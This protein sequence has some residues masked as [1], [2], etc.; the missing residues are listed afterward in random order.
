MYTGIGECSVWVWRY[1]IIHQPMSNLCCI[2]KKYTRKSLRWCV[3][4]VV[5]RCRLECMFCMSGV[6]NS[7]IDLRKVYLWCALTVFLMS[8]L[9]IF[10]QQKCT[11]DTFSLFA[12]LLEC[13]FPVLKRKRPFSCSFRE[14]LFVEML[15]VA[16][17]LQYKKPSSKQL[18]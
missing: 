9:V 15:S 18:S 12:S 10:L 3:A 14:T 17:F 5:I 1:S 13:I 6:C 16:A 7:Y 11:N 4:S 8:F 2:I